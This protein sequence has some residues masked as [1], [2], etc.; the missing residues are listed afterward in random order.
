MNNIYDGYIF[1]NIHSVSCFMFISFFS[2]FYTI[3]SNDIITYIYIYVI[4][5]YDRLWNPLRVVPD[6]GCVSCRVG[7]A[8]SVG[9][10][11][12]GM[13]FVAEWT[14]RCGGRGR[15]YSRCPTPVTGP[16][17][18]RRFHTRSVI[19]VHA[20][21][22]PPE[23]APHGVL[24]HGVTVVRRRSLVS[25]VPPRRVYSLHTPPGAPAHPL[26]V[27]NADTVCRAQRIWFT[28]KYIFYTRGFLIVFC[29]FF[30][31]FSFSLSLGK[32]RKSG[33]PSFSLRRENVISSIGISRGTTLYADR[34]T[35]E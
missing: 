35:Y 3:I 14:R 33:R 19:T 1:S 24:R 13:S 26:T 34:P 12:T 9:R 21:K 20:I 7:R 16:L 25:F 28:T 27:E 4:I 18:P 31:C 22:S 17:P 23:R 5:V 32:T 6:D 11:V 2:F 8:V 15:S 29:C 30:D 10:S